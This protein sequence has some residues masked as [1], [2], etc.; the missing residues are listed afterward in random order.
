MRP[1]Q[2]RSLSLRTVPEGRL[3]SPVVA[4]ADSFLARLWGLMGQSELPPGHALYLPG[5]NSIHM[6]FMRFAID[7]LFLGTP[8]AD[9]TQRV[10]ALRRA[11]PPWRGVVWYVRGAK[12]VVELPSGALHEA[13][14]S[15]GDLVKLEAARED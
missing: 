10:V 5:T 9:G 7:C 2:T 13:G 3:V 15:V 12:G 8:A 14:L 1:G 11:L 4:L 6:L